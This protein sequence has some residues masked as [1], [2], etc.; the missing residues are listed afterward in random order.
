MTDI[1]K[2]PTEKLKARIAQDLRRE[3]LRKTMER[4]KILS[5]TLAPIIAPF[6]GV[7]NK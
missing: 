1:H 2:T 4:M 6:K 5:K 3:Q 7:K